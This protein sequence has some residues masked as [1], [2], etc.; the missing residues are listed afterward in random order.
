VS[1]LHVGR[2]A[3]YH[4][5]QPG[6][7]AALSL[8]LATCSAFTGPVLPKESVPFEPLA[9]YDLWWSMT[10]QC[11]GLAGNLT[12][13]RWYRAPA[14]E[15]ATQMGP[16][17]TG[18]WTSAG[19]RIV[20]ANER[21]SVSDERC[22]MKCC[23]RSTDVA[24]TRGISSLAAVAVSWIAKSTALPTLAASLCRPHHS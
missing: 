13:V 4:L 5:F 23:T 9:V 17:V 24:V 10:Q 1:R 18:Y 12:E 7:V 2:F 21:L 22:D 19:N 6:L 14:R 15:I 16:G 11:S 20:I 3:R 8:L